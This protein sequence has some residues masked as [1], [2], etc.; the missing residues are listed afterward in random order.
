MSEKEN[1][2]ELLILEPNIDKEFDKWMEW[3]DKVKTELNEHLGFFEQSIE[4]EL[5]DIRT[6][7]KGLKNMLEEHYHLKGKVLKPIEM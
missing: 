2:F 5:Q 4:E 3:A 1:L 7:I 6:E